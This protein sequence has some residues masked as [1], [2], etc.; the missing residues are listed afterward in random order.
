MSSTPPPV[1]D[2]PE[3]A[4]ADPASAESEPAAIGSTEGTPAESDRAD[5]ASRL[6]ELFP[7]LFG[8]AAKPL[9]L[10]IQ[11]DIQAR[12]PGVF[13]RRAL[14]AFLHRHTG[15]TSYLLALVRAT[16][17]F[18]LDGVASGPVSDEHRAAAQAELQRRRANQE[19]RR[20]L[21]GE[22]RRNRANLLRDFD[23]TTLARADFC[24]AQGVAPEALDDLLAIARREADERA[25]RVVDPGRQRRAPQRPWQVDPSHDQAAHGQPQPPR[26]GPRTGP[27]DPTHDRRRRKSS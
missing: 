14:S 7:A 26:D 23:A 20:A 2:Q 13:S 16:Q 10:R 5:C 9:K 22:Q 12:A 6:R 15:S 25:R 11:S 1:P 21:L 19:A 24:A 3:L 18:D 4:P 17:R 27:I 8:S